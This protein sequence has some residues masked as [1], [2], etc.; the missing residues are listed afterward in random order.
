M[1]RDSQ[2]KASSGTDA[3]R[4][5]LYEES[6]SRAHEGAPNVGRTSRLVDQEAG[7]VVRR[8]KSEGG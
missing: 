6:S 7:E 1:M 3:L 5:A 2:T 8:M 4:Q